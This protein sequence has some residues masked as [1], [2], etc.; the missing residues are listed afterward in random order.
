MYSIGKQFRVCL[1]SDVEF[2][3]CLPS[4]SSK[5]K[6]VRIEKNEFLTVVGSKLIGKYQCIEFCIS[7]DS[8]TL[9]LLTEDCCNNCLMPIHM[10]RNIK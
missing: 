1:S 5:K 9:V 7:R 8:E 2:L 6:L 10:R 3:P 4:S